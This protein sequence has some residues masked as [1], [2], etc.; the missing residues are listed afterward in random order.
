MD[1]RLLDTKSTQYQ[2]P[3]PELR[4]GLLPSRNPQSSSSPLP[5]QKNSLARCVSGEQL[6][7]RSLHKQQERARKIMS[8][9]LMER[10][11]KKSA[12]ALCHSEQ[13]PNDKEEDSDN[14]MF[15]MFSWSAAR[16]QSLITPHGGNGD[17]VEKKVQAGAPSVATLYRKKSIW[18]RRGS[19]PAPADVDHDEDEDKDR[20]DMYTMFLWS[21]RRQSVHSPNLN[22]TDLVSDAPPVATLYRRKS[23]WFRRGR[24]STEEMD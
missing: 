1:K 23:I 5:P 6:A 16:Q 14:N 2:E 8:I 22:E 17:T 15:T 12:P 4:R 19:L 21:A 24:L 18:F 7:K 13:A 11:R 3:T 10:Q 20:S 9:K